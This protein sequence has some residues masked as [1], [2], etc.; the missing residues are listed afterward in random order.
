MMANL[1][2]VR[3]CYEP[4]SGPLDIQVFFSVDDRNEWEG[5]VDREK[6]RRERQKD[7]HWKLSSG[8]R[9]EHEYKGRKG[10]FHV[11][12][13]VLDD[14]GM[15]AGFEEK[16]LELPP[17]DADGEGLANFLKE[18]KALAPKNRPKS[19]KVMFDEDGHHIWDGFNR[20]EKFSWEDGTPFKGKLTFESLG[21]GMSSVQ[22]AFRDEKGLLRVMFLSDFEKIVHLMDHGVLEGDFRYRRMG[23]RTGV[24]LVKQ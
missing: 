5:E 11:H 10:V 24:Q 9:F 19:I 4:T 18:V 16:T 1:F 14:D 13:P 2:F 21:W 20:G 8:K 22:A 23:D 7:L 3:D 12:I 15:R 17:G 6:F